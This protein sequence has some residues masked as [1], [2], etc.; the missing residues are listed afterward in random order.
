MITDQIFKTKIEKSTDFK[1]DADVVNV[2]DDMVVRS[3]PLYYEFQRMITEIV[4]AHIQPGTSVYD[5]GCST[6][7]TFLSLN[8]L[9]DESIRFVGV[10]ESQEYL[11]FR[12]LPPASLP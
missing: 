4:R 8:P 9:L 5:L 1:F 3:V 6:G 11:L 10:D 12:H 2:F 7:T